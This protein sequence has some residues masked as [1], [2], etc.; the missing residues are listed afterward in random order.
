VEDL[1]NWADKE[2]MKLF[3]VAS[4][5]Q[6]DDQDIPEP[7]LEAILPQIFEAAEESAAA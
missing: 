5:I 7:K 4:E 2:A 6:H 1:A 3:P